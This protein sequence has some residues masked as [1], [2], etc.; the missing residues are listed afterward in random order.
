MLFT[1]LVMKLVYTLLG[2]NTIIKI[3]LNLN[4]ILLSKN[5]DQKYWREGSLDTLKSEFEG[6]KEII[7]KFANIPPEDI[8][9]IL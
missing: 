3:L 8:I 2:N 6:Q 1:I 4:K 7:S 9:G 5:Y